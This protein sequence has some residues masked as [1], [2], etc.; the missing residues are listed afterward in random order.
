[1]REEN[2][3]QELLSFQLNRVI[4]SFLD[5]IARQRERSKSQIVEEI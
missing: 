4:V 5:K 1:M 2:E 3:R